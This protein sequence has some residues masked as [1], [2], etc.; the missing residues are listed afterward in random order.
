MRPVKLRLSACVAAV[1]CLLTWPGARADAAPSADI[2]GLVCITREPIPTPAGATA[3][4]LPGGDFKTTGKNPPGWDIGGRIVIAVDAPQGKAYCRFHSPRGALRTPDISAQPGRPYLV[5]TW[6]RSAV[7]T[8][9]T[10]LF[11][12]DERNPSFFP[13]PLVVPSTGNQWR[14]LGCYCWMPVPCKT[15]RFVLMSAED[16]SDKEPVC[17]G[18]VR[19]RTATE[20]EMATAYQSQ[21]AQLPPRDVS[22]RPDDGKNLALSVA[23]WEGRAGIPGKPFVIWA[24]GSSWTHSQGDGYGLMRAIRQRFP[25]AP[26]IVYKR[27]AGSGT[28]WEFDMGWVRQFVAAEQPDLVFTYTPGTPEGLDALLAEIRRRTTADII[29]PTIH[30]SRNSNGWY[31]RGPRAADVTVSRQRFD[32]KVPPTPAEIAEGHAKVEQVRA[33][34]RKHQAEFVENRR[35]LAEYHLRTGVKPNDILAD[36]VHQNLHGQVLVWESIGRHIAKPAQFNYDPQSRERRIAVAP[37]ANTATEQVSLSG[38]WTSSGGAVHSSAA[39][40]RLKVR[41]TGNRIDVLGQKASNGGSVKVLIDGRPA[42]QAP[43]FYTTFIEPDPKKLPLGGKNGA[44]NTA[45]HAVDLGTNVVP[46]TWTIT[47]TSDHGDYHIEGSVTGPDGAGNASRP[48]HSTSGQIGIDPKLWRGVRIGDKGRVICGNLTGDKFTFDV[49]RCARGA[50]SF[51][52]D[53]TGPFSVALVENLPNREH[54]LEIVAAGDGEVTID[55]LYV[56]QPPEKD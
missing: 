20:A 39:G 12:S 22:P 51:R 9:A 43:V 37:P 29:I 11:T 38:D 40:A 53:R 41:F 45:P 4:P 54:T 28:P 46:Q 42:Q 23:K 17:V 31:D 30:F 14:H 10:F 8:R 50:M 7:E 5:S 16:S 19:M 1:G 34:C 33:I 18:D 44:G 27:H 36:T 26:P 35:E 49:Y 47:M 52:A 24:I 6:L 21:R 25:H 15:I 56:F 2:R 48:F 32:T 3:I 13:T 55:G